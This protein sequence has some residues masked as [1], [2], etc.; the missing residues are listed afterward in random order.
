MEEEKLEEKAVGE[1]AVE[2]K[3]EVECVNCGK[4]IEKPKRRFCSYE[5]LYAFCYERKRKLK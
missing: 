4:K 1:K 2:E 5:C 3:I